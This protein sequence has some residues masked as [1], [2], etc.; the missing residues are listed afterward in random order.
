[1]YP[2]E[3]LKGA[4]AAEGMHRVALGTRYFFLTGMWLYPKWSHPEPEGEDPL[5]GDDITE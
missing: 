1:M 5:H 2:K 3:L 4:A